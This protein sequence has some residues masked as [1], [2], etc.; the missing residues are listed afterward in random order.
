MEWEAEFD[1][2]FENAVNSIDT[3]VPG[4][5]QDTEAA[6]QASWQQLQKR[7][8]REARRAA[9]LKRI[10]WSTY[11]AASLLAGA[12]LF[13]SLQTTEAF[14]PMFEMAY[15]MKGGTVSV[16]YSGSDKL[17][18]A[19]AKTAPPPPD[20]ELPKPEL[21]DNRDLPEEGNYRRKQASIG[22]AA[23]ETQFVLPVP[24][25]LP[26]GYSVQYVML[27]Y[28]LGES[29]AGAAKI[30]YKQGNGAAAYFT[31]LVR[32]RAYSDNKNVPDGK[33]SWLPSPQGRG[34][35]LEWNDQDVNIIIQGELNEA[36]QNKVAAS[37]SLI[38]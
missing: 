28:T 8:R 7:L 19:G 15:K 22:E 20:D 16:Q 10:K 27:H 18:T 32:K 1:R 17:S 14:R 31:V 29:K 34:G 25:E 35:E 9:W 33:R 21:K 30:I 5:L 12:V 37:M 3:S 24:R 38:K 6:A 4:S 13:H 23:A 26:E 11:A 36:E 2:L